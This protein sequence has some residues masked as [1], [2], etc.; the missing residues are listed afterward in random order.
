MPDATISQAI[1]SPQPTP[2]KARRKTLFWLA[3]TLIYLAGIW[4][5]STGYDYGLPIYE[6]I[7][8]RRNLY[9]I[10]MERGFRDY[11]TTKPGYPPGV[12]WINHAARYWPAADT[13]PSRQSARHPAPAPRPR[14]QPDCRAR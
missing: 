11:D 4:V 6:H 1:S 8:E 10:Y 3:F 12:L 7:D 5:Y 2:G 13:A 9:E 14:C